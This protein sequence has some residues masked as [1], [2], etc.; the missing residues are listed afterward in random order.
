MENGADGGAQRF[1]RRLV[2]CEIEAD[3]GGEKHR[4]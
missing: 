3:A 2:G 4:R 1:L